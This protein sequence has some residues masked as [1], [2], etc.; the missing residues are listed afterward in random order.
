MMH[1]YSVAVD[2]TPVAIVDF[3][4]YAPWVFLLVFAILLVLVLCDVI[5]S[6]IRLAYIVY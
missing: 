4:F 6:T 2:T 3:N 1:I 5:T